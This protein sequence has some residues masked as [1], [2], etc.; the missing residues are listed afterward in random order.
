[1]YIE[2]LKRRDRPLLLYAQP[3]SGACGSA[4]SVGIL[5]VGSRV[6]KSL[7]HLGAKLGIVDQKDSHGIRNR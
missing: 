6:L 5:T 3:P 4:L 2:L 7:Q 1:M